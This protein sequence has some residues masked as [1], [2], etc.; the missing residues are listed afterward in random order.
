MSLKKRIEWAA[1]EAEN[2]G[3]AETAKAM[4]DLWVDVTD[5]DGTV[6]YFPPEKPFFE[7]TCPPTSSMWVN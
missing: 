2:F 7:K 1:V 4:R 6:E 5:A 3:F